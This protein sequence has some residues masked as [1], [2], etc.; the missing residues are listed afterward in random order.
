MSLMMSLEGHGRYNRNI[1]DMVLYEAQQRGYTWVVGDWRTATHWWAVCPIDK[2]R[3]KTIFLGT[4]EWLKRKFPSMKEW[5][6]LP[7]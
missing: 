1:G 7:W 6:D 2:R 4:P 5:A 3:R